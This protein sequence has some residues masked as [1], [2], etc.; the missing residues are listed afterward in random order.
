MA[1]DNLRFCPPDR[2]LKNTFP[3]FVFWQLSRPSCCMRESTFA[4][5]SSEVPPTEKSAAYSS[6]SLQVRN[7]QR[8]SSCDTI[9]MC[10]RKRRS[11]IGAPLKVTSPSA[12]PPIGVRLKRFKS[13][14]LPAPLGPAR[15]VGF[16]SSMHPKIEAARVRCIHR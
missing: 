8:W 10:S 4:R 7:G 5:L 13:V 2:P 1:R 9:D 3:H 16:I 6:A 12:E 14:V 11:V 15:R